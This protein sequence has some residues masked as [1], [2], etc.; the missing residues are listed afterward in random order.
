[1][2]VTPD[3]LVP[4]FADPKDGHTNQRV[5]LEIESSL[6]VP[7]LIVLDPLSL[8]G[9]ALTAQI[10]ERILRLPGFENHLNR[11]GAA[12]MNERGTENRMT[13]TELIPTAFKSIHI[14]RAI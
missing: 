8:F 5:P 2:M 14:E 10:E 11:P 12:F 7:A 13:L 6:H 3:N 1:M 9:T 4:G